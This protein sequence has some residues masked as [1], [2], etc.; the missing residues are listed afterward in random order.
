MTT[1]KKH[2]KAIIIIQNLNTDFTIKY[3]RLRLNVYD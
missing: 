3:I 1:T 2:I